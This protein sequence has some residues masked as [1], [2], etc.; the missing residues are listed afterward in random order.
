MDE[1]RPAPKKDQIEGS[2]ENKPGS[3]AGPGED[4][5]LSEA[6]ETSLRNKLKEHN[7]KMKEDDKPSHT[8]TT[9]GQLAAVYRRGAGAYSTS[10]RPGKTRGQ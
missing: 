1:A 10:Y 9:Y 5:K 3:A 2:D 6:V 7:D 8:R 4:I